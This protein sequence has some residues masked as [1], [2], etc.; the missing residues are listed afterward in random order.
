MNAQTATAHPPD[1]AN[2]NKRWLATAVHL[3]IVLAVAG[4]FVGLRLTTTLPERMDDQ[5]TFVV[6]QTRF[7]PD[8]DVS[9][10]VVVQD[11]GKGKPIADAQ[12]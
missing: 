7:A 8:S 5:Q 6:G 2:G 4:G 3:L 12:V 1:G 10:R 9:V 11:F